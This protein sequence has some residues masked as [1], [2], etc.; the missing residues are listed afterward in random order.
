MTSCRHQHLFELLKDQGQVGSI[1]DDYEDADGF[2]I[3]ATDQNAGQSVQVP[4]AEIVQSLNSTPAQKPRN[5]SPR[6]SRETKVLP[7]RKSKKR[8][9][10]IFFSFLFTT[11]G[12]VANSLV[13]TSLVLG[14][15]LVFFF[16]RELPD[17]DSLV[18]YEPAEITRIY[19]GGGEILDEFATERR[20]FVP[21]KNIPDLVQQAF[22]SAEDKNFFEHGGFDVG[23][24]SIAFLD[25]FRSG[26]KD[27]RGASTITQQVLKN[28]LLADEL[29]I[30]RKIK[31]YILANRIERALGK[32]KILELYLNEIY[33]GQNTYGVAAAARTYFNK[34][35]DE[36]LLRE[37]AVLA[38]LPKAPSKLHPV[39]DRT[40]LRA[41]RNYVL[42]EMYENGYIS[43]DTYNSEIWEPLETVQSGD[44]KDYAADLPPRDHF[45][46]EIRRQLSEDI[47]EKNFVSGGLTVQASLDAEMQV[48]AAKALRTGLEA[49]DRKHGIWRPTGLTIEQAKLTSEVSWRPLLAKLDIARDIDL[50]GRW[51]PAVV[52]SVDGKT[53]R[54]GIEDI[55]EASDGHWIGTRGLNWT[56]RQEKDGTLGRRAKTLSGLLRAGEVVHVRAVNDK[57]GAF[58][59]WSLRQVPEIQG[60]FMA[61]EVKT[62]RVIAMQGGFS[63]QHSAFNRATQAK[64]QPGSVFKPFVYAAALESGYNPTSRVLDRPIE[65]TTADGVWRPKNSSGSYLGQATMRTGLEQSRNLMAISLA[66][67]IGLT[68]IANMAERMGAYEK[69]DLHLANVLGAQE[70]TLAKLVTAYATIANGGRSV[71]PTLVDEVLDRYGKPLIRLDGSTAANGSSRGIGNRQV[72]DAVT[73]YQLTSMMRGVVERGTARRAISLPVPT[74]GKTGTTNGSKDVWFVGFT[75]NL[76]AGCYMGFDNPRPLGRGSFGGTM[77]APVFQEFMS[78]AVETYG[79]EEFDVPEGGYLVNVNRR[80]GTRTRA[81][82]GGVITEFI[83]DGD[84]PGDGSFA[85]ASNTFDNWSDN[86]VT[87]NNWSNVSSGAIVVKPAPKRIK[88]QENH[89]GGGNDR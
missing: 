40:R 42:K 20:V 84:E 82:G 80:S 78:Q 44:L 74:A 51:Y 63:Y 48:V 3:G 28:F 18:N 46:D 19:S 58:E 8:K 69:M 4:K 85:F 49:Y 13:V 9:V 26:G 64:R 68:Q 59:R 21:V 73:A 10:P 22:I 55:D 33:L 17:Y 71:R 50:D 75:S 23:A 76:V 47:G 83:R 16:G 24:I 87:R 25:A 86:Q 1:A 14:L 66:Q 61:M 65:I 54:I 45:T 56:R 70:T 57:G 29:L 41:R 53:A 88:R 5:V 67:D 27:V 60:G 31:E 39:R 37:V 79:G 6:P 32:E 38:A 15:M 7:A 43:R 30:E 52:L 77:C 81:S 34:S 12:A 36:L 62:G 89:V 72:L 35:L 2:F 11:A